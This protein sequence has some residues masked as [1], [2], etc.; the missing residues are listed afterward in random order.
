MYLRKSR[1]DLEAEARGEGE[2]LARH[3]RQLMQLAKQ[4][5][6]NVTKIY[7]EIVSGESIEARPVVQQLLREVE[8]GMWDGVLVVA[9][10]RLARGNTLDQG[11][12]SQAFMYSNTLI[13]TPMKIYDPANEFDQEY[14]EFGLFMSRREY[15]TINRRLMAGKIAS[16]NEGKWV[17]NKAPYGYG[18]VKV[19]NDKGNTL[20]IIPEEAEAV[21]L[22]YNLYVYDSKG[23]D[24][25]CAELDRKGY[26]PRVAEKWSPYTI[27]DMLSNPTYIGLIRWNGRATVKRAESGKIL[28]SRPR[29]E[30]AMLVKGLH[31]PILD[32]VLWYKAQDIRKTHNRP[33]LNAVYGEVKNPFAGL[34]VCGVCGRKMS[35]KPYK[36][37]KAA[38]S[39][40]CQNRNCKNVSSRLDAVESELIAQ[41][42]LW[43]ENLKLQ[44]QN[45]C[46]PTTTSTDIE[47]ALNRAYAEL[48]T[49]I[50]QTDNLHDLLEQGVYDIDMFLKRSE[51]LA[52]K[53]SDLKN[54]IIQLK[55]ELEE[56]QSEGSVL[57]VIPKI[58]NIVELYSTLDD[59]AEKN[60]L[61]KTAIEKIVYTKPEG[62][63]FTGNEFNFTLDIYPLLPKNQR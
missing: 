45:D 32:E 4:Y 24:L 49:C 10:D 22:V 21:R 46:Y 17:G 54:K 41:L 8:A 30:N 57:D 9:V 38:P 26:K 1:A 15:K 47:N 48:D 36:N 14:F 2:T 20:K 34:I 33:R 12:I 7:K 13:Y 43:L 50:K 55:K 59:P 40:I 39:L 23:P 60:E 6:L 11:I 35:R 31:E 27:R 63:R 61:L 28:E 56:K 16:V 62:G 18:I 37:P 58:E 51:K 3:E 53:Q 19:P 44:L 52:E 25:I 42:P 5:H 29:N